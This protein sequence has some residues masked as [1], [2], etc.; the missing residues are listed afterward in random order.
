M[1]YLLIGHDR[2]TAVQDTLISLMPEEQHIRVYEDASDDIMSVTVKHNGRFI[3]TECILKRGGKV[4]TAK[5]RTT[6]K[7]IGEEDVRWEESRSIKTAVYKTVCQILPTKPAWGS[8]T[9]VKPSKIIRFELQNGMSEEETDKYIKNH[10]FVSKERRKLCI[11]CA[12]VANECESLL[13]EKEIQIYIGIAFCPAKCSYCSFVSNSVQKMGHL[14]EPYVQ[15]VLR[16]ID[17]VADMVEKNGLTI[18]SIY[19][20]GGTPTVLNDEQFERLLK[21]VNERL[22]HE[23]LREY[24]VE[25]GRPETINRKK[26]ELMRDFSVSRISIN[27]QSMID[28][29]LRGVGRNHTAADIEEKYRL[30]REVGDFSI[31]MDLIAGL[32]GDTKEG[33]MK[34][35]KAVCALDPDNITVHSLARKK[36]AA[37]IYDNH[38]GLDVNVLNNAHKYI[39][40]KGYKPY[41]IYRQKYIAGGL[42]NTGFAKNGDISF[43]NVAMMEELCTVI[44]I[45]AGGVS[46]ITDSHGRKLER[47]ANPKYPKEYIETIES[48]IKKKRE[49][50][51]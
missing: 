6:A 7:S 29:V 31:N 2:N 44:A 24:S 50:V 35:V 25:A 41:Y 1:K 45:G 19:I 4:Y 34:S 32:P 28:S 12:K 37:V 5:K 39:Y 9:G 51:L 38:Y 23:N 3:T 42:E 46:K 10:F 22:Y 18:G 11:E 30:A 17:A 27:P 49:L 15:C 48:I 36:G 40:S 26:L 43:Y 14:L 20:G 13:G 8:Q 47:I 33:L 21:K 16:E